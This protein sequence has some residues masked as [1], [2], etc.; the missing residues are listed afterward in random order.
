[1]ACGIRVR[2][3]ARLD[4]LLKTNILDEQEFDKANQAARAEKA[5]LEFR[6]AELEERVSRKR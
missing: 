4:N 5:T 2:F 6:R 3:K 1:M